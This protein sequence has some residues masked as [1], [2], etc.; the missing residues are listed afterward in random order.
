MM[1]LNRARLKQGGALGT[2]HAESLHWTGA[3]GGNGFTIDGANP[4]GL[5]NSIGSGGGGRGVGGGTTQIGQQPQPQA[6][7][8]QKLKARAT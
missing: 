5:F 1:Q 2:A 8:F 3:G 7:W 6:V 4:P